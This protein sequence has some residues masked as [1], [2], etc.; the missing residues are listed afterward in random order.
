MLEC[1]V[2]HLAA[3]A[4][5]LVATKRQR[6]IEDVVAVDPH[7]SSLQL[8]RKRMRLLDVTRPHARG[9]A[10]YT[11]V[12]SWHD[13]SQIAERDRRYNWSEDL[14]LPHFHFCASVDQDGRLDEV[15]FVALP[16]AAR[17]CFGA[18]G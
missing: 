1:L 12:S 18:F 17:D 6:R 8:R 5:L 7:G 15:A 13:F 16:A 4:R 10:V 3:P 11:V 2:P 9:K 14:L